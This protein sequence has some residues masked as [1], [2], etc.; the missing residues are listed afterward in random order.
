MKRSEF[1][2][3]LPASVLAVRAAFAADTAPVSARLGVNLSGPVD[4]NTEHPFADVFRL[5][6]PWISQKEGL[7]WGKGPDL[8]LDE[9]G[10]VKRLDP[11]CRAETP[12][13]TAG[14][15]PVGDYTCLY[16]GDGEVT[17]T[18]R[19][20][21]VSRS[22]GKV[23]VQIDAQK[24]GIF[25]VLKRTNPA[26]PVR[27][28]RLIQPGAAQTYRSQRFT[29]SFLDRWRGLAAIRFMDWMD[30]NGSKQRTWADRAK[31][32]DATWAAGRGVPVEV[33]VDLCNRLEASPWFC[34]PHLVGDGY[35]REFASTVR[36]L[37]HPSLPV[38][39][40]YSNEV[41]N[42]MFEQH[43]YAE[44]QGRVVGLG[45]KERPWEGACVYYARRSTEIFKIW[46]D[47]FGGA[48]RLRRVLAWQ[49]AGGAWWTDNLLLSDKETVAHCDALAIAP[50]ISFMPSPGGKDLDSNIVGGWSVEQLLDRVEKAS[51]PE[52]IGWM[53]TQKAVAEKHR[54]KLVCYE[55]GQHLV[56]VAGGENNEALTRLLIEANHHARMGQL[57]G[58][59]LDAWREVG[60][61]LM[62]L[63]SSVSQS[64]KWGSW[65]LLEG[66]DELHSPKF[67]AVK[68]WMAR[69]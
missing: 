7:P 4:W 31:P 41:W 13:L 17:F 11:G 35:V 44:E 38:Y 27:N 63:F 56:G 14:H 62:C 55:S 57:Y 3:R 19:V 42:G 59:Y 21:E 67:D 65:G 49:A 60:G 36:R 6:R 20:N 25:L 52:C 45:P 5:A 9:H 15:A 50:Y 53:K 40:E 30:T 18:G 32:D 33:M 64:S 61:D 29:A 54:L 51:L 39:V 34:M 24:D 46:E 16:E 69:R 2:L 23:V 37:L 22:P 28:I 26:D 47:V 58:R 12:L 10:W 8:G 1:L 66:A 48:S 43:R 68:A